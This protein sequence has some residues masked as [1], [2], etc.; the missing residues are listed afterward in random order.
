MTTLLA[1]LTTLCLNEATLPGLSDDILTTITKP[2]SLQSRIL[3]ALNVDPTTDV[4]IR[5]HGLTCPDSQ[6]IG[7][8]LGQ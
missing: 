5:H 8:A 3:A 2:T 7:Y 6:R 4:S 1:N